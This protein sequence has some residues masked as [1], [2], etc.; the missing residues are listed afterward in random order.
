MENDDDGDG[1]D[2]I[3]DDKFQQQR[4]RQEHDAVNQTENPYYGVNVDDDGAIQASDNPYYDVDPQF[5]G[6]GQS[7]VQT[8]ENPLDNTLNV[9]LDDVQQYDKVPSW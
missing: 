8:N 4:N 7:M 9:T 6:N 3:Y 5:D 1:Y 2:D